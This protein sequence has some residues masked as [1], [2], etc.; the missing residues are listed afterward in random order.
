MLTSSYSEHK[1]YTQSVEDHL[2]PR[3]TPGTSGTITP[4][5]ESIRPEAPQ[6]LNPSHSENLLSF[7]TDD[8]IYYDPNHTG[9]GVMGWMEQ[10]W[11]EKKY[12]SDSKA[13]GFVRHVI[14]SGAYAQLRKARVDSEVNS[15]TITTSWSASIGENLKVGNNAGIAG[16]LQLGSTG[17]LTQGAQEP[18]Q[19]ITPGFAPNDEGIEDL[20]LVVSDSALIQKDLYVGEDLRVAGDEAVSGSLHVS[21]SIYGSEN[22]YLTG[23]AEISGTL[24]VVSGTFISGDLQV[25]GDESV[26]GSLHVNQ[27]IYGSENLYLTGDANVGGDLFVSGNGEITDFTVH[28]DLIVEGSSSMMNTVTVNGNLFVTDDAFFDKNISVGNAGYFEDNVYVTGS[29]FIGGDL[30]V[31]GTSNLHDITVD[32]D[33]ELENLLVHG[34]GSFGEDV[35]FQKNVVVQ[36]NLTVNGTF[37]YLNVDD[38]YVKD[39]SITLASG[40]QT[41][42]DAEG[43]G[44]DIAG[45]D[46]V[47]RYTS[48][49]DSMGLNKRLDVLGG[50]NITGSL[51]VTENVQ[52]GGDVAVSGSL[53]VSNSASINIAH[54]TQSYVSNEIVT[55]SLVLTQ[56]VSH[57][58]VLSQSV[59][60]QNVTVQ[61]VTQQFVETSSVSQS[62]VISESVQNITIKTGSADQLTVQQLIVESSEPAVF[63]GDVIVNQNISGSHSASFKDLEVENNA[64]IGNSASVGNFLHISGG[65]GR[66]SVV[67]DTGSISASKSD[68]TIHSIT[69]SGDVYVPNG[70]VIANEFYGDGS[71]LTGI[72]ASIT[73]VAVETAIFSIDDPKA[74]YRFEHGLKS[75]NLVIQVYQRTDPKSTYD[76]TTGTEVPVIIFPEQVSVPDDSHVD[77]VFGRAPIDGYIVIAKAGH[78]I[79]ATDLAR[80]IE[81]GNIHYGTD[82]NWAANSFTAVTQSGQVAIV[83]EYVDTPRIGNLRTGPQYQYPYAGDTWNSYL[84]FQSGSIDGY[85]PADTQGDPQI[86][87]RLDGEGNLTIKGTLTTN[88]SFTT[89]D[90]RKKTNVR[91]IENALESLKQIEG[92]RFDWKDGTGSSIGVIAQN[93]GAIYP[94]LTR[95]TKNLEG[96]EIMTVNYEGLIGVLIE[97][98]KALSNRIEELEK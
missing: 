7:I 78:V 23:D 69:S 4:Y 65:S 61:N 55:Q 89:S 59:S 18:G 29:A 60:N 50:E 79:Q 80:F 2:S 37:T 77:V 81:S 10:G 9:S 31:E 27:S 19:E 34:S 57:S 46:V 86:V 35:V 93:I 17:S 73:D 90:I 63:G 53:F 76:D 1:E 51:A 47:F 96:E 56:S 62:T 28:G 97:A 95:L 3:I 41:P 33:V 52:V 85:V 74:V 22:F 45:A 20:R 15:E 88:G 30:S 75:E 58:T 48:S 24:K 71:H 84:E 16:Y 66:N 43:A 49:T 70:K 11:T 32:G 40:A 83:S 25:V 39:R 54:I 72:T 8:S 13:G 68:L 14:L 87:S 92:V 6:L 64:H 38:L 36:E 98:V 12:S 5:T 67:I 44:F 82:G 42:T 21:S 91:P 94:E 26:T